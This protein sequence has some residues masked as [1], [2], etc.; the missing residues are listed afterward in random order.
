MDKSYFVYIISNKS[1]GLYTG[2]TSERELAQRLTPFRPLLLLS[3]GCSPQSREAVIGLCLS[4]GAALMTLLRLTGN[5]RGRTEWIAAAVLC[6]GLQ[7]G[8]TEMIR[9]T[10]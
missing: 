2:I 7:G 8:V 6:Y 5:G 4:S 9:V 1:R 10:G 3:F